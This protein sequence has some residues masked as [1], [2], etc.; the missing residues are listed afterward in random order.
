MTSKAVTISTTGLPTA[1]KVGR[2]QVALAEFQETANNLIAQADRAEVTDSESYAKGGDLIKIARTQGS[3]AEDLRK[4][5]TSPFY[6]LYTLINKAFKP[7]TGEFDKVRT[8]VERKMVTWKRAEDARLREEAA[9]EARRLEEEALAQAE[10]ET[11]EEDQNEVLEEAT[12]VT[13]KL[14][15][16]ARVGVT[17]GNYGSSTSSAKKYN[18]EVK[19]LRQFLAALPSALDDLD[20]LVLEQVVDLKRSGLNTLAQLMLKK[21]V[22]EISGAEFIESESLRIF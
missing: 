12:K 6:N 11:T 10:A 13:E 17:R 8:I 19:N 15:E 21:G 22:K 20:G 2:L 3:K 5:I 4:E 9:K 7:V 16:K 14:I 1:E 18:T